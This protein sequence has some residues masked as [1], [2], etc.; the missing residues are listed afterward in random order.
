MEKID[1]LIAQLK[2]S[3][4]KVMTSYEDLDLLA[5]QITSEDLRAVLDAL[6][7]TLERKE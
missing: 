1:T 5:V 6:E 7:Q 4:H 2:Y 3:Q